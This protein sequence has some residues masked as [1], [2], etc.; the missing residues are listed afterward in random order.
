MMLKQLLAL[1]IRVDY[2]DRGMW[3]S[4]D[5]RENAWDWKYW[6][7]E[8]GQLDL[9]GLAAECE[10]HRLSHPRVVHSRPWQ[11]PVVLDETWSRP[12]YMW[13]LTDIWLM[14]AQ[15]AWSLLRSHDIHVDG[16]W[17]DT[18]PALKLLRMQGTP[19]PGQPVS[20]PVINLAMLIRE[21]IGQ[22]LPLVWS[23]ATGVSQEAW[24]LGIEVF[25]APSPCSDCNSE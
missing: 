14:H 19:I 2:E 4:S 25:L 9:L 7:T 8:K 22:G 24:N 23:D 16:V 13:L 3:R 20:A 15:M 18:K 17:A 21:R 1:V 12:A 6:C 10:L 5:V 11:T